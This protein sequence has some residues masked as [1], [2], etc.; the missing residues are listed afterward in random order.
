M[1]M[2]KLSPLLLISI[3][4]AVGATPEDDKVSCFG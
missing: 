2:I 3:L 1:M 4:S